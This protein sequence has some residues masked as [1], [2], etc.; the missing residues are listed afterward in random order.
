[1]IQYAEYVKGKVQYA[2][3]ISNSRIIA[4]RFGGLKPEVFYPMV[5]FRDEEDVFPVTDVV[6][7]PFKT[8][9][10]CVEV[11]EEPIQ[12]GL[13]IEGDWGFEVLTTD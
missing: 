13:Y 11:G 10:V 12:K 4:E 2:E 1:M 8:V 5:P 3:A 7:L 6:Q 9:T